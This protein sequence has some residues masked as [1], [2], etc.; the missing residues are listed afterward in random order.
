MDD[1]LK[2]LVTSL[3]IIGAIGYVMWIIEKIRGKRG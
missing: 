1:S 3:A 2:A